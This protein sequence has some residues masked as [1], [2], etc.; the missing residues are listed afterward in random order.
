M[1]R[2]PLAE[3]ATRAM[4]LIGKVD[5]SSGVQMLELG[6]SIRRQGLACAWLEADPSLAL[7]I[8]AHYQRKILRCTEAT[9]LPNETS[10]TR[11]YTWRDININAWLS[12]QAAPRAVCL[13]PQAVAHNLCAR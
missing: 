13:N 9:E 12:L 2:C 8:I 1:A 7:K 10:Y 5:E 3:P 6:I 4:Y 11:I